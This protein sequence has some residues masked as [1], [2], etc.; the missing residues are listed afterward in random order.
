MVIMKQD[1]AVFFKKS[2]VAFYEGRLFFFHPGLMI[3]VGIEHGKF[4]R[5]AFQSFAAA[6]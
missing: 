1:H 4:C 3:P 5:R 2:L 6:W